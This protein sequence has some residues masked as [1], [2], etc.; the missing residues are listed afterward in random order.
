[1]WTTKSPPP[2][3]DAQRVHAADVDLIA[4][5]STDVICYTRHFATAPTTWPDGTLHVTRHP[6]GAH[7]DS[8]HAGS[9]ELTARSTPFHAVHR[10]FAGGQ[11]D[12][13]RL[14]RTSRGPNL[15]G[16]GG[17]LL[18]SGSCRCVGTGGVGERSR[19]RPWVGRCVSRIRF[20]RGATVSVE[21]AAARKVGVRMG[22]NVLDAFGDGV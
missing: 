6:A 22:W 11:P 20:G 18:S 1:M 17:W 16:E 7:I 21:Q 2:A 9:D 13:K 15:V 14:Y 3:R 5:F 4:A 10:V 19:W 12:E 8:A